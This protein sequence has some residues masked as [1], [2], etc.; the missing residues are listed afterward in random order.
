MPL[1]ASRQGGYEPPG[2]NALKVLSAELIKSFQ[3]FMSDNG[4]APDCPYVTRDGDITDISLRVNKRLAYYTFFHG[5]QASQ[6][7][8]SALQAYWVVKLHPFIVE[9]EDS[10]G[11]GVREFCSLVNEHFAAY[12]MIAPVAGELALEARSSER[13]FSYEAIKASDYYE[14]LLYSLR[15]RN[16]PIDS[17]VLLSETMTMDAFR[18]S[19]AS[20]TSAAA[21]S[22]VR[23]GQ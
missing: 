11:D 21:P 20:P 17:F 7:K 2:P 13:A 10:W 16:I 19:F 15:Y 23:D 14:K 3:D 22:G 6:R 5:I 8:V 1:G 9:P 12:L 18:Q 4:F